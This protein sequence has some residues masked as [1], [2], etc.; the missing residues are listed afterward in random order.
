MF[1]KLLHCR[2]RNWSTPFW[3]DQVHLL[4]LDYGWKMNNLWQISQFDSPPMLLIILGKGWE[5]YSKVW[6]CL[7]LIDLTWTDE[8]T[9]FWLISNFK[10]LCIFHMWGTVFILISVICILTGTWVDCDKVNS[11]TSISIIT[12]STIWISIHPMYKKFILIHNLLKW[13]SYCQT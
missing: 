7:V 4:T 9:N 1:G 10:L 13:C 8:G 11:N 3:I 6:F 5:Y 2:Y 12:W